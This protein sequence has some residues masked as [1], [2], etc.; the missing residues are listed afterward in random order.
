MKRMVFELPDDA[1]S[2]D[3]VKFLKA[4]TDFAKIFSKEQREAIIAIIARIVSTHDFH[5][6]TDEQPHSE[7][8]AKRVY[9]LE[10]KLR[11]HRHDMGKIFTAKPEF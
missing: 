2:D 1:V 6:Y 5:A 3:L 11:N 9:D 4:D 10:A 7:T 8:I